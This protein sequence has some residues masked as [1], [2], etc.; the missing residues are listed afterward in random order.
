MYCHTANITKANLSRGF[1]ANSISII[2]QYMQTVLRPNLRKCANT[3]SR[4]MT[5]VVIVI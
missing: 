5:M 4:A 2:Q 1:V 3:E